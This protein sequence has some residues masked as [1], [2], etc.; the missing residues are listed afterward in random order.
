MTGLNA[1]MDITTLIH[2]ADM[3]HRGTC[4]DAYAFSR[5]VAPIIPATVWAL[6][7][8]GVSIILIGISVYY[9]LVRVWVVEQAVKQTIPTATPPSAIIKHDLKDLKRDQDGDIDWTQF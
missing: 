3:C 6:I 5:E 9:S 1:V 8:A 7:W 2:Y 4:N